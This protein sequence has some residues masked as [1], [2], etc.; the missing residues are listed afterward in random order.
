VLIPL[1]RLDE[2]RRVRITSMTHGANGIIEFMFTE[3]YAPSGDV[4]P[5]AYVQDNQ[6]SGITAAGV[7]VSHL[8]DIPILTET[9]NPGLPGFYVGFSKYTTGWP[10][11]VLYRDAG[12]GGSVPLPSGTTDVDSSAAWE[13]IALNENDAPRAVLLTDMS[14]ANPYVWDR[15]SVKV[16][17]A[18][19]D[20]TPFSN[21]EQ[22]VL[23]SSAN[24][25][26]VNGEIMQFA[27]STDLG[28]GVYE[29]SDFVRG[30]RGTE[31]FIAAHA[32]GSDMLF[33]NTTNLKRVEQAANILQVEQDYRAANFNED[34]TGQTD[35]QFTNTGNSLRPYAP[36]HV[37]RRDEANGDITLSWLPRARQNGT[38]ESGGDVELTQ[39]S[40]QYE[41]DIFDGA[42]LKRTLIVADAREV[43]Y[44]SADQTTDFGGT[45]AHGAMTVRVYQIG[46]IIGRGFTNPIEL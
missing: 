28:E 13:L 1:A 33:I 43:V 15:G 35:L 10:G 7:T 40:E 14:A 41:V 32:A 11:G 9:E 6:P 37:R 4:F 12:S 46:A 22:S 30:K 26:I 25:I 31:G 17:M 34:M 36:A 44:T 29:L 24:T 42:N 2:E 39:A 5:S 21:S 16:L 19:P 38:W 45:P 18:T 8:L 23:S 27:T 20:Y 3:H